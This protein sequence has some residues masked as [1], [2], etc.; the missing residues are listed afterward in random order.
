MRTHVAHLHIGDLI[1]ID[2]R[3]YYV[4]SRARYVPTRDQFVLCIQ[5]DKP[6]TPGRVVGLT[7]RT[8]TLLERAS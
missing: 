3:R 6:A 2:G 4:R 7:D 1:R 5:E 8:V